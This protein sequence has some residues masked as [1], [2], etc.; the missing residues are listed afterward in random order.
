MILLNKGHLQVVDI[1]TGETIQKLQAPRLFR[2]KTNDEFLIYDPGDP[3]VISSPV[4]SADEKFMAGQGSASFA[5]RKNWQTQS[6]VL[7]EVATGKI[8]GQCENRSHFPSHQ[9]LLSPDAQWAVTDQKNL[10]WLAKG[11]YVGNGFFC[12][13]LPDGKLLAG[14]SKL[15]PNFSSITASS[16]Q[17]NQT[18]GCTQQQK[19]TTSMSS[20]TRKCSF[21]R[22]MHTMFPGSFPNQIKPTLLLC[23]GWQTRR[24][25]SILN[26]SS[27]C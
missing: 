4:F 13:F 14:D 2:E 11:K 7:W 18:S 23:R 3:A 25:N 8:V 6:V 9:V 16:C 19:A 10:F 1:R 15:S 21:M 24:Q 17:M 5:D 20:G 12:G 22:M 26:L 27:N